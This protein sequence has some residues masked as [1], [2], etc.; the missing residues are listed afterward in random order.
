MVAEAGEGAF[1]VA[2]MLAVTDTHFRSL[3]R[4]LSR[5]A[6][7]WTEMVH[8]DAVLHN[9]ALLP[10]EA[11][12]KTVVLQLGGSQPSTLASAARIGAGEFAYDE[13]NLNCGCP[14][15]KV[16]AKKD[17]SLCFGARLMLDA[18]LTGE[19]VRA[20][21]EAVDVPVS[22]KCR[23]GCDTRADYDDLSAFVETVSDASGC[24][25]FVVHAR[26]AI[27]SGLS[28]AA[29]RSV[30]P[31]RPE[32]VRRLKNDF[33]R[34]RIT[35]NGGLDL[36]SAQQA[37]ADGLDG[38]MLGRAVQRNP[39]L[40]RNVDAL[41]YGAQQEPPPLTSVVASYREYCDGVSR[42][43]GGGAGGQKAR[44]LAERH[45]G[46]ASLARAIRW[47]EQ[48]SSEEQRH[49]DAPIFS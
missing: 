47:A 45:L 20:M 32:L 18:H 22:V 27:L 19:C 46:I 5:H 31:L 7:L 30:P 17:E 49:A 8:A 41:F 40:L 39:L 24:R 4:R 21:A 35:L 13:I 2:P 12:Q 3:C 33:P 34:M 43:A 25:H 37:L 1:H 26:A 16:V 36:E 29:N 28:T 44:A 14:S 23:L 9:S 10:F 38:V 48:G 11:S 42:A 15:A 6:V